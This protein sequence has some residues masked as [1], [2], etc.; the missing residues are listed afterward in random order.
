[1][2][3]NSPETAVQRRIPRPEDFPIAGPNSLAGF[4][5]RTVAWVIDAMVTF[6]PVFVVA[7]VILYAINP[8]PEPDP[9]PSMWDPVLPPV[10]LLAMSGVWVIYQ[11]LLTHLTG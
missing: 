10:V 1:M 11:I 5:Q 4:G 9:N 7:A 6:L 3:E 2:D 8:A